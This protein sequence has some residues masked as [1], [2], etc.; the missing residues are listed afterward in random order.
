MQKDEFIS[1]WSN[2][3]RLQKDHEVITE[4]FIRELEDLM[5]Q[6]LKLK[7]LE[8]ELFS[9]ILST[10]TPFGDY[11]ILLKDKFPVKLLFM[12]EPVGDYPSIE[13]AKA[14]AEADYV[15]RFNQM[16]QQ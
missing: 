3:W 4:A 12:I 1:K 7:P 11:R 8:W 9:N 6:G 13:E 5:N 16:I 2:W 10:K 15:N 14:A